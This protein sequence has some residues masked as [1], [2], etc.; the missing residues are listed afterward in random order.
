METGELPL[1][2]DSQRIGHGAVMAFNT[3]HPKAWRVR[4]LDGDDDVGLDF[5]VQVVRP[6]VNSG[7]GEYTDIFRLQLKGTE[8]PALSS[9]GTFY[10][11]EISGSTVRYYAR[12]TEPVML[13][14]FDLSQDI[15]DPR[16]CS[17]FWV[18]IHDEIARRREED[19]ASIHSNKSLSFRVPV[20]NTLTRTLDISPDL[21]GFR[22]V[23]SAANLLR[24][25]I[26]RSKSKLPTEERGA[27]AEQVIGGFEGRGPALLDAMAES[28]SSPWPKPAEGT[29][30]AKLATAAELL[31]RGNSK[32]AADL[33]GEAESQTFSAVPVEKAEHAFLVGRALTQIGREDEALPHFETAIGIAQTSRYL[34]AWAEGRLRQ[35]LRSGRNDGAS[36][37][38]AKL[39]GDDPEIVGMRARLLATEGRHE[40][41]KQELARLPSELA[42]TSKAIVALHR[43]DWPEVIAICTEGVVHQSTNDRER[44]MFHLLRA[45]GRFYEAIGVTN[46]DDLEALPPCGP[47]GLNVEMLRK[48]WEDIEKTIHSYA[49][50][51][52]PENT[53][54]LADIWSASAVMLGLEEQ[55]LPQMK[56]AAAARPRMMNLQVALERMAVSS[57]DLQ[58]ALAANA[59]Q[60]DGVEPTFR[61]FALLLCARKFGECLDLAEE[62]LLSMPRDH[63]AYPAA[64]S[65]VIIAAEKIISTDRAKPFWT[66]LCELPDGGWHLSSVRYSVEVAQKGQASDQAVKDLGDAFDRH[67]TELALG[68]QYLMAL[69]VDSPESADRAIT[70]AKT[71]K[72]LSLLPVE[73]T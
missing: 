47:S 66:A 4:S 32:V 43:N 15:D 9:D 19:P 21:S 63:R 41:A 24:A 31:R 11:V 38:I 57:D 42:L 60:G 3:L 54:I 50:T 35:L 46:P 55:Q 70:V 53:E 58:T 67:P 12:M 27:F 59:A 52:W 17:G 49:D 45:R 23:A 48:C 56:F 8:A 7:V 18:W 10:S 26:G 62:R 33:L 25:T 16:E 22:K 37:I 20:S 40:D 44:A 6:K 14:L 61:R 30:A 65:F 69:P 34:V 68:I 71:I 39:K 73:A 64:L 51:G 13:A 72:C 36:D 29:L 5:Q 1:E 2:S 28:V